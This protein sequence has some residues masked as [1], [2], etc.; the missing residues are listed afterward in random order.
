MPPSTRLVERAVPGELLISTSQKL[1]RI[2]RPSHRV[3]G[4]RRDKL[5]RWIIATTGTALT[6]PSPQTACLQIIP[7]SEQPA[8]PSL[9][10][11][12]TTQLERIPV[13]L[14]HHSQS[15]DVRQSN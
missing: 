5:Q 13:M 1:V 12:V 14:S 10:V 4:N 9:L 15:V 6:P 11:L 7:L 8:D 3:T 2:A